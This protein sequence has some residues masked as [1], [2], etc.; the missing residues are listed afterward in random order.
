MIAGHDH[1]RVEV[2]GADEIGNVVVVQVLC[3]LDVVQG[4]SLWITDIHHHGALLTQGL[5]LFGRD[6]FEFAHG[7]LLGRAASGV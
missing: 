1:W 6:T 7:G 3:A 4:V 2:G 5:G